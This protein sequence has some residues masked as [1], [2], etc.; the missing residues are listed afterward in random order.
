MIRLKLKKTVMERVAKMKGMRGQV[1]HW[2]AWLWSIEERPLAL[3]KH[4]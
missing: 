1:I 4:V 3:V 2:K